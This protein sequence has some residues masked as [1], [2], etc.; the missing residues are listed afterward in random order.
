MET[1]HEFIQRKNEEYQAQKPIPMKDIGRKGKHVFVR[2]AWTFMP[3]GGMEEKVFVFERLR[4][5]RIDGHTVHSS[6]K[7]GDIEYRIGY[8][9]DG[10]NG[11]CCV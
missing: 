8:Y 11:Q 4:R 1:C 6:L 10:K 9:M 2:E 7:T 3:Q 5:E